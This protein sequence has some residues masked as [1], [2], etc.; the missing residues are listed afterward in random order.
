MCKAHSKVTH[1]KQQ[2]YFHHCLDIIQ[3]YYIHGPLGDENIFAVLYVF[4]FN[5]FQPISHSPYITCQLL[6][7]VFSL[8]GCLSWHRLV[9][10]LWFKKTHQLWRTITT[11]QLSR[12]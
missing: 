10:T 4:P 8:Y 7:I 3:S 5:N 1:I 2:K 12:F 9:Y 11:T 6:V